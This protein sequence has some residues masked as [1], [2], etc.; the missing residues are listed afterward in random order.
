[1]N[2]DKEP[3]PVKEIHKIKKAVELLQQVPDTLI[4]WKTDEMIFGCPDCLDTCGNYLEIGRKDGTV[5]KF[6]LDTYAETKKIP[7]EILNFSF[8]M[9]EIIQ[10]LDE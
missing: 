3:E 7:K 6:Y 8:L 9:N 5:K 2:S 4:H 1:M 10:Q